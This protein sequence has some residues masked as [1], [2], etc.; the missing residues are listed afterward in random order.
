MRLPTSLVSIAIL[1]LFAAAAA[2]QPPVDTCGADDSLTGADTLP[3]ILAGVPASNDFNL[4]GTGCNEQGFDHVTCLT[5]TTDCTITAECS[6]GDITE[7][8]EGLQ[9]GISV[10]SGACNTSPASCLDSTSGTGGS[11]QINVN[12]TGGTN[13]CFVCERGDTGVTTLSLSTAGDCGALPVDLQTFS[14]D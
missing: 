9:I 12:V 4:S 2:A 7:S 5:P 13:Y 3:Q 14:V 1:L 11:G 10:F 8:V 6:D